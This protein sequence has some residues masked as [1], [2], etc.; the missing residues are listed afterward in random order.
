MPLQAINLS[1]LNTDGRSA[2]DE[3]A[4]DHVLNYY[5]RLH[6][7]AFQYRYQL[8]DEEQELLQSFFPSRLVIPDLKRAIMYSSHAVLAVLNDYANVDAESIIKSSGKYGPTIAIGDSIKNKRASHNCLKLDSS[9]EAYR[10]TVASQGSSDYN[11]VKLATQQNITSANLCL[12]GCENCDFIAHTAVAVHSMYDIHPSKVADI[13]SKHQLTDMYVY[14]YIPLSLFDKNYAQLDQNLYKIHLS[15]GKTK[16]SFSMGD[17]SIPYEHS[18]ETW[19]A[20]SKVTTVTAR[21]FTLVFERVAVHGPLHI[22]HIVRTNKYENP[23][24]MTIPVFE[25]VS[26]FYFVPCIREAMYYNFA[27][28]QSELK[29]YAVPA[30]VVDA[31]DSFTTRQDE[32]YSW[33]QLATVMSGLRREL[34][35][36]SKVFFSKW[37]TNVE[38]YNSIVFSLFILGA[39]N[40]SNRTQG[41]SKTFAHLKEWRNSNSFTFAVRQTWNKFLNFFEPLFDTTLS[42][43]PQAK[44]D[45]DFIW[46]YRILSPCEVISTCN[47]ESNAIFLLDDALIDYNIEI[48]TD[49]NTDT[50][51]V[52]TVDNSTNCSDDYSPTLRNLPAITPRIE[53]PPPDNIS[54][55]VSFAHLFEQSEA[56]VVPSANAS[57][58]NVSVSQIFEVHD[59]CATTPKPANNETISLCSVKSTTEKY[60][61]IISSSPQRPK[62]IRSFE[63]AFSINDNANIDIAFEQSLPHAFLDGQCILR[64]F[65]NGFADHKRPTQH[66]LII[67]FYYYAIGELEDRAAEGSLRHSLKDI[68]AYVRQGKW[69]TEFGDHALRI[70]SEMYNVR[71]EVYDPP[72][73][74]K[75]STLKL[76]LNEEGLD[77]IRV[78]AYRDH[79]GSYGSVR[80][81]KAE[82]YPRLI[83]KIAHLINDETSIFDV[84]A[85][86]G[87]L[88]NDLAQTYPINE[89]TY[90]YY[91]PGL[92]PFD[93]IL[94]NGTI[95]TSNGEEYDMVEYTDF[96]QIPH[97]KYDLVICDAAQ[98]LN[99]E[100]IVDDFL[101]YYHRFVRKGGSL[102]IKTF[103]NPFKL[104]LHTSKFYKHERFSVIEYESSTEQYYLLTNFDN[105][106]TLLYRTDVEDL[107]V[108]PITSHVIRMEPK[109]T[110]S[111]LNN[112]FF[113]DI[114]YGK[115]IATKTVLTKQCFTIKAITGYASAQKTTLALEKYHKAYFIA[116]TKECAKMIQRRGARCFT[117]HMA[118]EALYNDPNVD[119]IVIEEISQVP[120]EYVHLIHSIKPAA[121]IVVCGDVLQT[122]C[123]SYNAKTKP[124][125]IRSF[126]VVNN[127]TKTHC[128]PLDIADALNRKYGY[129]IR[130]VNVNT[131]SI[132]KISSIKNFS[133][134]QV[135][136][137]NDSTAASLCKKG[138][139]A[140]TITTYQ[141]SRDDVIVFYIDDKAIANSL[142]NRTEWVYTALTRSKKA[143]VLYGETNMIE[144]FF[145]IK[146][147]MIETY[148]EISGLSIV[149]DVHV[150]ALENKPELQIPTA[151]VDNQIVTAPVIPDI[152]LEIVKP[153]V[154][155]VNEMTQT[156]LYTCANALP[157]VQDGTIKINADLLSCPEKLFNVNQLYSDVPLIKQQVSNDPK[158]TA[159]TLVK[160]YLKNTV[161]FT[162]PKRNLL[163]QDFLR[164]FCKA[165][166]GN[167]HSF[168][169]LSH[170]GALM[171]SQDELSYHYQQYII[172]L[173]KKMGDNNASLS[174]LN[175]P[176]EPFD[177]AIKFINKKQGKFVPKEGWDAD[178]KVGQGVAS[179][180]KRINLIYSAYARAI[181]HRIADLAKTNTKN[182]TII[183]TFDDDATISKEY[184]A[185]MKRSKKSK[186]F[187]CDISEWD[188]SFNNAMSE[189]MKRIYGYAGMPEHLLEY[190]TEFRSSWVM[191]YFSKLGK[192]KAYGNSKQ[193]SGNPFTILENTICNM[194]L[195]HYL[196]DFQD[197]QFAL[198]KGDDSAVYC[199]AAIMTDEGLRYVKEAGSIL[200]AH[201]S[202]AGDF[203]SFIL[204]DDG[205][206]PDLVRKT[207]RVL[208]ATYLNQE[209]LNEVKIGIRATLQTVVTQNQKMMCCA[210]NSYVYNIPFD[211]AETLFDFLMN[212]MKVKWPKLESV[213]KHIP[214]Y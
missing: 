66:H 204:T 7:S 55:T 111:F 152:A 106:K 32:S 118:I 37:K 96:Q 121:E 58:G 26:D 182:A 155:T 212:A 180:S 108:Q 201:M 213:F 130:P 82:K 3:L 122:P 46:G 93:K 19:L 117:P 186:W 190:W 83:S 12:N 44:L 114:E 159:Q 48:D 54:N 206:V 61:E 119:Q 77:T 102:L 60:H 71:V 68:I 25:Q 189:F 4:S 27:R 86:P 138:Y 18:T 120:V 95:A 199:K 45:Y 28:K 135:I 78:V 116:P 191:I 125:S 187:C 69:D 92:K 211:Q 157:A 147:K 50:L 156:S 2:V 103:G 162:K 196:Y 1:N 35:I 134:C 161:K 88:F 146:G 39:I 21:N 47:F 72:S 110:R 34:K 29:H 70:L 158:M 193:F 194:A 79:Y 181:L 85:A 80:G 160:R 183:A 184:L 87:S 20:W 209:H 145:M 36:G 38:D 74:D 109:K 99:S 208:G 127:M 115:S 23:I 30:H 136:C 151:I 202:D 210:G 175:E 144:Q 178:D 142:I 185:A 197:K 73:K 5:K 43:N 205:M 148:E 176:F 128:I 63:G 56:N 198:F 16:T 8:T 75:R 174:E 188:S 10:Y 51:S 112:E 141:G 6:A 169:K 62:I 17:C 170:G 53:N 172:S 171:I 31:V 154:R 123:V 137:Y 133:K 124:T 179:M 91:T 132:Y 65:W 14:I 76:V 15:A 24:Y 214:Q 164:G 113:H 11:L 126:G 173:Q 207:C 107:Y 84:S 150:H 42:G 168:R 33:P 94:S 89:I 192:A 104:W 140:N 22:I 81:G 129:N 64:A 177:E 200:K 67:N 153:I 165:V 90:G 100:K 105:D 9:R 97:D 166:F 49:D 195:M 101:D 57:T 143:L 59:E 40:R 41:I 203:A 139:K 98:P 131:D 52:S 167:D 149:D 13:F 163:T